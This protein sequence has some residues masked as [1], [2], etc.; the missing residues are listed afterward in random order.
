MDANIV[1]AII[2][3]TGSASLAAMGAI[4]AWYKKLSKKKDLATICTNLQTHPVMRITEDNALTVMCH[5]CIK[6]DLLNSIRGNVICIP[7]QQELRAL[8]VRLQSEGHK[9]DIKSISDGVLLTR[10]QISRSQEI[11]TR[12][13]PPA[14]HGIIAKLVST[15][16]NSLAIA[17]D[18]FHCLYTV[19]QALPLVFD[20][21]YVSTFAVLAQWAQTGNQLN[22]Q[23][24]GVCWKERS[25][26]YCFG[27]NVTDAIRIMNPAVSL[28]QAALGIQDCCTFLVDAQHSI[29][30]CCGV[31][32]CLGFAVSSLIG[33]QL[34]T[35]QFGVEELPPT[36]DLRVL[37]G[38]PNVYCEQPHAHHFVR[39]LDKMGAQ[40]RV[41]VFS[42]LVQLSLPTTYEVNVVLFMKV[43][44]QPGSI[45]TAEPEASTVEDAHTR[46]AFLLSTLTHPVRRIAAG[47]EVD[48]QHAPVVAATM[49]GSPDLPYFA[50]KRLLH[51]QM[52]IPERRIRDVS[53]RCDMKLQGDFLRASSLVY[54]WKNTRIVAEFYTIGVSTVALMSIH[55][56]VS[57]KG[58]EDQPDRTS[59]T[60]SPPA[61]QQPVNPN[62]SC[63]LR[64]FPRLKRK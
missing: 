53:A 1:A 19:D 42:T 49:D 24:N 11:E 59:T 28:M 14:T 29:L 47:C 55:R 50:V 45:N 61:H 10:E 27:G 7:T 17:S 15:H 5:D 16:A 32:G 54:T 37:V 3:V 8:L 63:K 23:L 22:G 58:E 43:I 40:H 35:F 34:A 64:C 51:V 57:Y 13:F 30:G 4:G 6:C 38:A 18:L 26:G 44:N 9:V 48:A 12:A 36:E 20:I 56:P 25:I 52:G 46:L 31:Q 2:S 39:V 41:I 62:S 21:F 33:M 60:T